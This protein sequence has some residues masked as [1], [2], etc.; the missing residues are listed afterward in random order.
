MRQAPAFFGAMRT[1][2]SL[3]WGD[4]GVPGARNQASG[5]ARLRAGMGTH[6]LWFGW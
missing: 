4:T 2:N 3:G 5:A 6:V 1:A